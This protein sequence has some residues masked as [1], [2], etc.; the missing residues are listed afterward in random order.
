MR[1][2]EGEGGRSSRRSFFSVIA[3]SKTMLSPRSNGK[4]ESK[5]WP[6]ADVPRHT[7]TPEQPKMNVKLDA[8]VKP[9]ME[10]KMDAR[11]TMNARVLA[12]ANTCSQLSDLVT[13]D[14]NV[15]PLIHSE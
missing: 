13:F 4:D 1:R 9:T 8:E 14:W 15:R 10:A 2:E 3:C 12:N 5:A 6:E 11:E 7:P